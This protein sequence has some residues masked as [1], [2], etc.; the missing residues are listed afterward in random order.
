[1]DVTLHILYESKTGEKVN[2]I[3]ETLP[4]DR[5]VRIMDDFEKT[6][7][8]KEM[9]A[10]EDNGNQWTLKQLRK[11]NE[12]V[13]EEPHHL[14]CYFDGSFDRTLQKAGIG[15]VI[16][17]EQDHER[18][19]VRSNLIIPEV[20]SNNEAEY[21]AFYHLVSA[22]EDLNV[23]GKKVEFKG[24]SLVV[25]NQLAGE[26]P[27]YEESFTYWLDKIEEKIKGMNITPIY[28]TINRKEN[29]EA[30]QLAKQ[31]LNNQIINSRKRL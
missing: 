7:R 8:V 23:N 3:S 29:K 9:E 31:A 20:E 28:T 18:Y 22:L 19:R 21:I 26:W 4:I 5:A 15:F 6:G 25:L 17:Y 2:F 12:K 14:I 30:D 16:Y 13:Q 1:M 10:I 11:L 24:D 27:C